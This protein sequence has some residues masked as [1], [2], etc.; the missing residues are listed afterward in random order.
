MFKVLLPKH[1]KPV[2]PVDGIQKPEKK[3]Q[4]SPAS[5]SSKSKPAPPAKPK[6]NPKLSAAA[7]APVKTSSPIVVII[8]VV[9]IASAVSGMGYMHYKKVVKVAESEGYSKVPSEDTRDDEN[10]GGA[11]IEQGERGEEGAP[12]VFRDDDVLAGD[13]TTNA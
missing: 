9:A 3:K 12:I 8:L 2:P 4:P 7:H 5:S 10:D 11:W 1:S 13:G 6:T